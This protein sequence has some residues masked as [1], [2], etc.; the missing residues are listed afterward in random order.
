MMNCPICGSQT[1]IID[2]RPSI[3]FKHS[4]RRR[5]MCYKC[6]K[7]LSTYEVRTEVL[8]EGEKAKE[9]LTQIQNYLKEREE[10]QHEEMDL[11]K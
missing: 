11:N 3:R 2:T 6:K 10:T 1:Y 9:L 7:R 8:A 5:R 4:L